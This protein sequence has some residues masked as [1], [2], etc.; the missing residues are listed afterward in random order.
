MQAESDAQRTQIVDLLQTT[1]FTRLDDP[2]RDAMVVI[3]QR[4]HT[5]DVAAICLEHGFEHLCLPAIAPVTTTVQFPRTGRTVLRLVDSALWPTRQTRDDLETQRAMLGSY[6]FAG[7]YQQQPV[8]RLEEVFRRNWWQFSDALPARFDKV[9]QSWVLSFKDGIGNDY[10]VGL[11]AGT[12]GASVYLLD[13]FKAKASFVATCQAIKAMRAKYPSTREI[14]I[15]DA[16]NGPAVVDA[17]RQ[18]VP[19]IVLAKPA[20]GKFARA[21]AVQPR[22]EARQVFLPQPRWPDGQLRPGRQ[23]VEDFVDTCAMFPKGDHDDDVDAFTQLVLRCQ[24]TAGVSTATILR[25]MRDEDRDDEEE[26]SSNSEVGYRGYK[27][28]RA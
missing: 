26:R 21:C 15:E 2:A 9:L 27:R 7:Q 20:G 23:W 11:I 13:R 12:I 28:F 17:L 16:A 19:G 10:V 5:R 3:M 14:I 22:L 8:P 6:A 25:G 4:L 24:R 1:L 18:E